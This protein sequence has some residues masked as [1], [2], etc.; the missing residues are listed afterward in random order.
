MTRFAKFLAPF[1]LLGLLAVA[2][3]PPSAPAA[4]ETPAHRPVE[5]PLTE[6]A[7]GR[8]FVKVDAPS[9]SDLFLRGAPSASELVAVTQVPAATQV[10]MLGGEVV[11]SY[12][13]VFNGFSATMSPSAAAEIAARAD[14]ASVEPVGVMERTNSSSV[15]F[16]GARKVWRRFGVTG[17][18]MKVAVV[19]T[20]VDYTHKD[21][22]GAGTRAAFKDNDPTIVERGSFPTKKVIDGYDF[23]GKR[24]DVLDF[25]TAND[26]PRPD[27]DPLDDHGHGTHVA[28]SC[29]GK[30][31]RGT[32][33]KGVAF[34]ARILAYK[35][36]GR[37]GTS[38]ADV[39]VAAYERAVDPNQDGSFRDAPD[40]LSFSGG[41]PY[42]PPTAL[43][44]LAA[45]RVV[46]LGVVFVAGAGNSGHETTDGS[47]YNLGAPASAPGVI[48][49][50]AS[51]DPDD[52]IAS[53]TSQGPARGSHALKPDVVAPGVNIRSAAVGSGDQGAFNSGTSMATPHVSGV[54]TLL[55][56]LHPRWTPDQVK[57]A[58]M[59]HAKPEVF[60]DDRGNV[61]A[62][63]KGAGRVRAP[64]AAEAVSFAIPSSLSFGLHELESHAR[65]APQVF[66]LSNSDKRSHSYDIDIS[67]S[68]SD[69][70]DDYVTREVVSVDG[71][72][73]SET[74]TVKLRPGQSAEV[75]MLLELSPPVTEAE[76]ILRFY[77]VL[78][79]VN[80][81]VEIAQRGGSK[82]HLRV[83]WHVIP[84]SVS[85]NAASHSNLALGPDAAISFPSR[86]AAPGA[87]DLYALGATDAI[88]GEFGEEDVVALGVRSFT[89]TALDGVAEG[90]PRETD[91]LRGRT[92]LGALERDESIAEPLEFAVAAHVPHETLRTL[93]VSIYID[94]GADGVFA[95]PKTQSDYILHK[96]A[97][98]FSV[99]AFESSSGGG[100]D[101]LYRP[102]F[103]QYD[104]NLI[105]MIA[106]AELI[107]LTDSNS[108][109]AYRV[110]VC[111][112]RFSGD[113]P[114]P[115]CDLAGF[116]DGDEYTAEFDPLEPPLTFSRTY[117]GNF[118]SSTSCDD[119]ITVSA[120]SSYEG[121][122]ILVVYPN[123][124]TGAQFEIIP[125]DSS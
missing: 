80:G 92:W 49:V 117:C 61:P 125:T 98:H 50:G 59:N 45:Q 85:N 100:C 95:D 99:C 105:G 51:S 106:D 121:D 27:R 54:A 48:A 67:T 108:R 84:L 71:G 20:G 4:G 101:A 97:G 81:G 122:S 31:V 75:A 62:T 22:G 30:G 46:D 64:L 78:P 52:G 16:I 32:V 88:G 24:Y 42:G 21:F 118:W 37:G 2:V 119:P 102:S 28:G 18:G 114:Q 94:R 6:S 103:H 3:P 29:C 89:G 63:V 9:V 35:V 93:D 8:Y 14:V 77:E 58:I 11:F 53:F 56:Q 23:V 38:S 115:E 104:S 33:G 87:A 1:I 116:G 55:L 91:D 65:T 5:I 39:L 57:A 120:G 19:D 13:R 72:A 83:P 113:V 12:T 44:S 124:P 40:V 73:F 79:G 110:A 7:I 60:E 82:D 68:Y 25:S 96:E 15:P 111:T 90:L 10:R 76:R 43:E 74:Q 107:G 17:K 86:D 66:T 41:V 26:I 69:Y 36:W 47:A 112:D 109:F 34:Q 70:Q 123:N